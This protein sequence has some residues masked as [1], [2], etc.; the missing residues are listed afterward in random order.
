MA[1]IE[2]LGSLIIPQIVGSLASRLGEPEGAVQKGLM[3]GAA[4]LLTGLAGKATDTGFLG[5]I[6]SLLTS[7]LGGTDLRGGLASLAGGTPNS[8]I[9]DLGGKFLG[10]VLGSNQ[11]A[12]TDAV[13]RAAGLKTGS[14]SGILSMAA[15]LVM[16][17]LSQKISEGG[18]NAASL[19]KMLTSEAP[20]LASLLPGGIGALLSGGLPKMSMPA[21]PD[22]PKAGMNW[23]WPVVLGLALLCGLYWFMNQPTAPVAEAVKE[24]AKTAETAVATTV[25][26]MWAALGDLFKRK[27][28][29]GIELSIP[30]LG[31]ETKLI[32]FIEDATKLVDKTTWFDFDRLLFDTAKATLQVESQDQLTSVASILKAFPNV[33][34]KIGGYT[35]NTGDKAAN[36]KLSADRAATVM[37]ELVKMGIDP[38]RLSSEGYGDAHPVADN[39]TEEGRQKNRRVSM[40]VTKK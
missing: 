8:A 6:L 29:N 22:A 28:P 3:G 5:Q 1:I 18:L 36:M 24:T 34:I 38:K 33:E 37:G 14:A 27:L 17:L 4:M 25:N 23:L 11:V 9:T 15:P 21:V 32:D 20:S 12:V 13:G 39:G 19:G 35:D 31:V 10:M 30:K 7:G 2:T 16:G 26:S 40:R